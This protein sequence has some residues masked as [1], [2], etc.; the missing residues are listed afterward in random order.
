[1]GPR[2][3][4]RARYGLLGHAGHWAPGSNADALDQ[5]V[6]ETDL[7]KVLHGSPWADSIPGLLRRLKE[8]VGGVPQERLSSA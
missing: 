4:A 8:R 6:S 5:E 3:Y 1:M 7:L 2:G